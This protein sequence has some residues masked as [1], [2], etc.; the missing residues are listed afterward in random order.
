M[1]RKEPAAIVARPDRRPRFQRF[2]GESIA[3]DYEYGESSA[4]EKT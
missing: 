4:G 2:L 1:L 3:G